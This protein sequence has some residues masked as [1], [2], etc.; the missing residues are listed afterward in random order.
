MTGEL[1]PE[2][3]AELDRIRSRIDSTIH[4]GFWELLA[5][6]AEDYERALNAGDFLQQLKNIDPVLPIP[7][8][9][10]LITKP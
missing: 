7:L 3:K 10:G 5:E 1:P 6:Y 9:G 8:G 2:K 4:F